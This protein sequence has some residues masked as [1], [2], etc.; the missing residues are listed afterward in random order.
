MENTELCRLYNEG[1]YKPQ[2]TDEAVNLCA[3]LLTMFHN[4][5]VR[6]IRLGLHSGG[7]VEEG[8]V[9]GAY[10]PAFRELVESRIYYSLIE[11]ALVESDICRGEAVVTVGKSFLSMA[12]GQKRSNI[13]AFKEK[14]YNLKFETDE[15]YKKYEVSVRLTK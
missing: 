12:I 6:V 15:N 8:Y 13:T 9:A 5:G 1:I 11:K 10:H 4:A 7:N 3:K 14:G 2:S